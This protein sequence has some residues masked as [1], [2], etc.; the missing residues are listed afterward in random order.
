MSIRGLLAPTAADSSN[1]GVVGPMFDDMSFEFLPLNVS[2]TR[3]NRT[4]SSVP[5]KYNKYGK[6]LSDFLPPSK[7]ENSGRARGMCMYVEWN[8]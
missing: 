2:T 7:S 6:W 8:Y 5:A 1:L 3:V 4:Y